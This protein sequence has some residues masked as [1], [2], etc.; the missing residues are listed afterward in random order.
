[1]NI[2]EIYTKWTCGYCH[3]AKALLNKEGIE[4]EEIDVTMDQDKRA[5]MIERSG[6]Q[7]VPQIFIKNESIGG[8]T[9]LAKLSETINLRELTESDGEHIE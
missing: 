9:E 8:Y 2:V 3:M 5:E 6:R 4:F 7:T 1:M